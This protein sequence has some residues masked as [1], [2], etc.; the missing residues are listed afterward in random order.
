[1]SIGSKGWIHTRYKSLESRG[2]TGESRGQN[3]FRRFNNNNN[4]GRGKGKQIQNPPNNLTC[5]R[6]GAYHPN[7]PCRVRQGIRYYCDRVGHVSWN[8]PERKRQEAERV[9]KRQEAER[10]QQQG[11]VF[12][13]TAD[14]AERLD[15]LIKG[16]CEIGGKILI[17]LFDT[18]ATQLFI[19]FEKAS[20]LGL[21]I[22]M[23][24][25]YL[26]VHTHASEAVVT[27][28]G[29]Q[30]V[31]FQIKY[32]TF[33]HDLICLLMTGLNLILGLD[34][35][36]KNHVL[37]DCSERSLQFMS[38]G[39]VGPMV[40]NG[41]YLNSVMI[42]VVN[43]F[44]EVFPENIPEYTS[45]REIEFAIEL[46][47]GAGPISIAPY[48]MS[49]LEL[50][51][52]KAR[53]EELM[54]K[55]FI[56]PCVFPWGA[57]VLLVRKNDGSMWVCID[58]RQL[59]KVTVKNKYPLSRIDD[60]MD[61][62][63]G[64][65]V[66]SKIDLRLTN[67]T[68]MFSDYMNRIF[69]PF[70]DKFVIVFIDDILIYSK[71]EEEHAEHLQIVLVKFRVFSNHKSLKY[72]FDQKELNIRQ[73]RWID[74]LEDYDFELSYH[75]GKANVV[76]NALSQKSLTVAWMMIKE[77]DLVS[78]FGE[79]RLGVE[80]FNGSVCLNQLQISSD[81]KSEIFKN[82]T[83]RSR[84]TE[85][86]AGNREGKAMGSFVGRRWNMEVQSC[87]ASIGMAPYEALYGRKCQSLLC[88]YESRKT[89]LLGPELV[90]ETAK[91]IKKIQ[92][93]MLT[94][95]S[96]QKSYANQ[97]QKPLEFDE[98]DHI[99]L[100]V[101]L[102]TVVGRAIKGK[103]LNPHYIGPFQILKRIGPM[104]YRIVVPLHLSNLHD[105]FHM[106]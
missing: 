102:T 9:Q 3:N 11:R 38:K 12:I 81:F 95:Q 39:S 53:L 67:A 106:S 73:R 42:P 50:A 70:L 87:H 104:A 51:K 29:C 1:M 93:R 85:G 63:Q 101:T 36:S 40:A 22:T 41:Y 98:G 82:S 26:Q 92:S 65:G 62:L 88:W 86:V 71:T 91:Q 35:L 79:L 48:R 28:L 32:R 99:F 20:E 105:M 47:P 49:P 72:L 33:V 94:A 60:L 17:A 45:S 90:A 52:L 4:Q 75:Q 100:R 23:L 6:C 15:T 57:S 61:Q 21:K 97:R 68:A 54:S 56:R 30:Q 31:L 59:N 18:W 43:E 8:C 14:G 64:A 19:S 44:L 58:Y 89:S 78:K 13:M 7:T 46:V 2:K 24:A 66:F 74:L 27:R 96:L 5:R 103:K 83:K 10:V 84:V 16:N 77:E 76:A 55:N 34:W 80:E 37:L 25:Y 69:C